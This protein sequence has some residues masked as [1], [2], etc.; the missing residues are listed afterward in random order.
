MQ[1]VSSFQVGQQRAVKVLGL[2]VNPADPSS[3]LVMAM[4]IR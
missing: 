2:A 1:Q 4:F 3:R